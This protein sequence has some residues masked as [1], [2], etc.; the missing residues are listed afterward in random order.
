MTAVLP[1]ATTVVPAEFAMA[2]AA[3]FVVMVRCRPVKLVTTA[4]SLMVT[5]AHPI[6]PFNKV[7]TAP[8]HQVSAPQFAATAL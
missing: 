2:L 3:A 4:I 6:A 7:T 1:L 8:V 5:D